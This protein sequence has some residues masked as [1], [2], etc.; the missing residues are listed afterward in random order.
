MS[1]EKDQTFEQ[2]LRLKAAIIEVVETQ[3]KLNDPPEVQ[4]T[5]YR[6]TSEGFS[7]KEAKELIG[8]VVVSEVFEVL[9]EGEPFDLNRYVEALNNLPEFP[10]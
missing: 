6:L 5:L 7:T 9:K 4:E 1:D 10:E 3:L 2:N 8:N